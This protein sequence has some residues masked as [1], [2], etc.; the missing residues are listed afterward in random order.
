[1][2]AAFDVPEDMVDE[3][4]EWYDNDHIP[5]KVGAVPGFL[6][7][8]RYEAQGNGPRFLA[9]YELEDLS[10]LDNPT[11]VGNLTG[12]SEGT[13]RMKVNARTFIRS[14]YAQIGDFHGIPLDAGD[15]E[16]R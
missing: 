14:V 10:V 8:R 11:Y 16:P 3:F 7:A 13:E 6:R 2:I 1:M 9:I 12:R 5:E 15:G 4:N